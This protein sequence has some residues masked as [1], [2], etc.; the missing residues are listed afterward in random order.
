MVMIRR[1][2]PEEFTTVGDISVRAYDEAG[3]LPAD[4][5]YAAV[6]RDAASR[7]E[8]A[9]LLVAVDGDKPVG[10]VTVAASTSDYAEISRDG[11]VEFRMLAVAPEAAGNG[12]GPALVDAVTDR[13]GELGARR[14]VLCV[15]EWAR[16]PRRLYERLG[17]ER[18]P[19]RD[20][21]PVPGIRLLGYAL[22]L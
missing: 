6:L 3:M 20:W 9:E 14:V 13:A 8:R 1:A 19:D 4:V 10:T 18:L 11:E 17:F 22:E 21:A 7:A 15:Q 12:I 5:D 16:R 2:V